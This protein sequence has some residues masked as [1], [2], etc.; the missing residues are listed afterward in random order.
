MLAWTLRNEVNSDLASIQILVRHITSGLHNIP[1]FSHEQFW[2]GSLEPVINAITHVIF[3]RTNFGTAL[4]TSLFVLLMTVPVLRM[5]KR[6]GG[7]WAQIA[8]LAFCIAG[9]PTFLHYAASPR[10]SLGVLLFVTAALLDIGCVLICEMRE[11]DICRRGIC[12]AFG[13]IVGIGFWCNHLFFPA[14]ATVIILALIVAPRIFTRPSFW[15]CAGIAFLAGS[16][17]FWLWNAGNGWESFTTPGPLSADPNVAAYNLQHFFTDK[18]PLFLVMNSR[19]AH[20]AISVTVVIASVVPVILAWLIFAPPRHIR[21]DELP[22]REITSAAKVQ[23][24]LLG[25]YSIVY[26]TYFSFTRLAL[27]KTGQYTLPLVPVFAV[28]IGTACT[29]PRFKTARYTAIASLIV[30]VI[31]QRLSIPGIQ[32]H[33]KHDSDMMAKFGEVVNFLE[34]QGIDSAY[35]DVRNYSL[36]LAGHGSVVFSDSANERIPAFKRHMGTAESLAV[37]DNHRGFASWALATGGQVCS[38]NIAGFTITTGFTPPPPGSRELPASAWLSLTDE[39]GTD[40]LA[41]MTD[42]NLSTPFHPDR[43]GCVFTLEFKKP[44]LV[45][46]IRIVASTR[47]FL[48]ACAVSGLPAEDT[49]FIKLSTSA[50]DEAKC[51][52][53]G[54]RFYPD[55]HSP[56]REVR[57]EPIKLSALKIEFLPGTDI[58]NGAIHEVQVL[59]PAESD[60]DWDFRPSGDEWY[61]KL[62]ALIVLLH[63]QGV[64]RLYAEHW[65]AKAVNTE[66][67]GEIETNCGNDTPLNNFRRQTAPSTFKYLE[68][69]A[70]SAVLAT[71]AGTPSAR[72]AFAARGLKMRE[73]EAGIFGTLFLPESNQTVPFGNGA[74]TG[75]AF[76]ADYTLLAPSD[77]WMAAILESSADMD[78]LKDLYRL[79]PFSV[80]LL[81]V[82]RQQPLTDELRLSVKETIER[83]TSPSV[84]S[85]YSFAGGL[86]WCGA[87]IL[88]DG[89]SFAPGDVITIRHYWSGDTSAASP[90]Q[91]VYVK[92]SGPNSQYFFDDYTF[93]T[94]PSILELSAKD[95]PNAVCHIDRRVIIPY[96]A[97]KGTY[98]MAVGMDTDLN[99]YGTANTTGRFINRKG[100]VADQIFDVHFT[101]KADGNQ[102]P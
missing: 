73:I 7:E 3:G 18:L 86:T 66:T 17:P 47:P 96:D 9:P 2:E 95:D 19:G 58:I 71:S 67:K 1:A 6:I 27:F 49:D 14:A 34:K 89:V 92:F 10:G 43:N 8:V 80:P 84:G 97:T 11:R 63:K 30:L 85:E 28:F 57:F 5:A 83:L 31:W 78:K 74:P 38:T 98:S 39:H 82:L 21:N 45:T 4:G 54:P 101:K 24:L 35:V 56:F 48:K 26:L 65:V 100:A 15:L 90:R 69:D 91:H 93:D 52:W 94:E 16:A 46:G 33:A 79:D 102:Q 76:F 88:N 23:M 64:R 68:L 12:T 61:A 77:I 32:N 20:S 55:Q 13:L 59:S 75:I 53:S 41:A 36:N 29:L 42:R 62:G 44:E 60:G 87:R 50:P 22:P 99:L 51:V 25:L 40:I 37:I 72:Y 81:R 70:Q